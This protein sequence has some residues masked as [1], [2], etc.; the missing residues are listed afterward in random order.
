MKRGSGSKLSLCLRAMVVAA[1]ATLAA[2]GNN[3]NNVSGPAPTPASTSGA[4]V[5]YPPNPSVPTGGTIDFLANLPGSTSAT[6]TWAVKSGGGTIT[7][8]GVYTAPTSPG[9]ATITATSTNFTGTTTV[10]V[11]SAPISGVVMNPAALFVN[12][13]STVAISASVG[14][15]PATVTEWDVNGTS[16][17]DTL[18][19][20][21]D[22]SGNYTAPLTPPPGGTTT[23]TARTSA[24]TG[25]S[26]ATVIFSKASLSGPYAFSYTGQDPKG[27]L[28]VVGSF[29]AS[30]SAGTISN[31]VEDVAAADITPK[32]ST[33]GTGTF[34]VAPDGTANAKLSDGSTW[35][36]VIVGNTA[37]NAG[38]PAQEALLVR[39]DTAGSGSGTINQQDPSV[40]N[41]PM[42][43]GTYTFGFSQQNA[44]GKIFEA[45]GKFESSG[46]IGN[47]GSLTPGE[48]DVNVAGTLLSQDETLSG[49]FASDSANPNSGRGVMI[50]N[51]K[52]GTF[53]QSQFIF[54]FYVVDI[55]HLKAI[56][57]DG[58]TY[59]EGD[60]YNAPNTNG[61]FSTA[62]LKKGNYAFT[63][64]GASK[65]G[66]YSAG[67]IFTSSGT[68]QL[69]GGEMD[70][71]GGVG[72][73]ALDAS[74]Q[75]GSYTV[76]ATLGRISLT[77]T[78]SASGKTAGSWT[79]A[80]YQTASG[81]MVMVE[82]DT[83]NFQT[84][85]LGTAYTQT[86]TNALQNGFAMNLTGTSGTAEEDVAGEFTVS[87]A[88]ISTGTLNSNIIGS[89]QRTG[90]PITQ[91]L[92][93][94]PSTTGRGT[95]TITTSAEDFPLAFYVIDGNT[96][97]VLES[98]AS[99]NMVGTLARQY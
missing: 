39:Y 62:S 81:A 35:E 84:V 10:T 34:S 32:T 25:N 64:Q 42:P 1:I 60:V 46:L 65:T 71:N 22:G 14:G 53:K 31:V 96:A 79:F 18:H 93:V 80:G 78:A 45:A 29:T 43:F 52:A 21:I 61:L 73:I 51:T 15:Q 58:T 59:A 85:M 17:G 13:G 16:G 37:A 83:I 44:I 33:G 87:N 2:C 3:A 97:L 89:G 86:S 28:N 20:T 82:T 57:I 92:I 26:A 41:L 54:A 77:I 40:V 55:T 38:K 5:I 74:V 69:S 63:W 23:I 67:G 91:A 19:G 36:F 68:G 90:I 8:S 4:A 7:S 11:T 50:L 76:D 12:A 47:T 95:A 24:G 70:V 49:S 56:E 27:F 88:A 6:F 30:G 48:W 98:D 99:R 66:P 9:S 72:N 94:S 75:T